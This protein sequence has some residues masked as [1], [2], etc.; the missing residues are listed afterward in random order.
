[1][2]PMAPSNCAQIAERAVLSERYVR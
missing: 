1:M 2:G